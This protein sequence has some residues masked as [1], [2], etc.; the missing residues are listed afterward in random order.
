LHEG[1]AG[2]LV[3]TASRLLFF[4][5]TIVGGKEFNLPASKPNKSNHTTLNKILF[6]DVIRESVH[7]GGIVMY[8]N[9]T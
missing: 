5:E 8:V 1:E 3:D 2:E 9:E 6:G 4:P 7:E